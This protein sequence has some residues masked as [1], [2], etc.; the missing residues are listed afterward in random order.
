[1]EGAVRFRIVQTSGTRV[2][3]D[4]ITVYGRVQQ[5]P[6]LVGDVNL[7]GEVNVADVNTI[8][9][10]ILSGDNNTH[11]DVNND[12]EINIADINNELDIILAP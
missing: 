9:D 7:D 3:I 5:E 6:E 12:G 11:C 1:M 10:A 2:N 8:I 4:N